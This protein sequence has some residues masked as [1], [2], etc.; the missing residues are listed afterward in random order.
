MLH[1]L[2]NSSPTIEKEAPQQL[3]DLMIEDIDDQYDFEIPIENPESPA[4][5]EPQVENRPTENIDNLISQLDKRMAELVVMNDSVKKESN[6]KMLFLAV[7]TVHRCTLTLKSH[8][9]RTKIEET[10]QPVINPLN[11]IHKRKLGQQRRSF[12]R[13]R[14]KPKRAE[15]PLKNPPKGFRKDIRADYF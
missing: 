14:K 3:P 13:I 2:C 7:K 9:E 6:E 10:S 11:R 8:L 1:R 12:I 4:I 15:N 5:T